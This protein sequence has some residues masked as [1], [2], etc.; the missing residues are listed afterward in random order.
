MIRILVPMA[1][2]SLLAISTAPAQ[3]VAAKGR[4]IFKKNQNTVITVQL[5]VKSK[6]GF[7]GTGADRESKQEVTGTVI[8]PSGLTAVALSSTDPTGL[9]Q[10]FMGGFGGDDEE[11]FK[12]KMGSEVSDVKLLTQDGTELPA[13]IVLRDKDLDLAFI[14]PK[15][16]PSAPMP[17]LDLSKSGKVDVFDE[18]ITINRLG[19]VAGRAYA[20]S[21]ERINAIV[22]RPR[23]FYVPGSDKTA[24]GL[25]CPAFTMDGKVVG[26]FVMRA[27]KSGGG[28]GM[29]SPQS[30]P[31]MAILLPADDV[32]KIAAQVPAPKEEK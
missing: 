4:E 3:D 10:S 16:R 29:F 32:R 12:L 9:I 25:G 23:L 27:V 30:A 8:D 31:V 26:L 14:R 13:E 5:V 22:Q 2:V 11:N 7:G 15:A 17:A 1:A 24:T 19:Q 6:F 28:A 21:I 20:A 18:V